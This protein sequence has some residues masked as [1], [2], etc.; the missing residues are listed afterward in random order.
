MKFAAALVLTFITITSAFG[1][2]QQSP[3]TLKIVTEDPNLPS[4]LFY[5]ATK[6][7]PLRLRPGTNQRITWED[8]DAFI[9]QQYIDFLNRMPDQ[10]GYE[11]WLAKLNQCPVSEIDDPKSAVDC[12]RTDVSASFFR[13]PEFQLKGY[14]LLRFYKV[15]LG[16]LPTYAEFKPDMGLVTGQTGEEFLAKRAAF[17]GTF[18]TRT[19]FKNRYDALSNSDYVTKLSQTTGVTLSNANALLS[20]LNAGRKTRAEVLREIVESQSVYDKF[21]NEAFVAMEYFGY[22]KR[23]PEPEGFNAWL[24]YLNK[25][26]DYRTMVWGFAYSPEYR[27]RF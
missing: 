5:G 27:N 1:Q 11:A 10:G 4:E 16:R 22:L 17:P 25:T 9:V 18:V 14:Y 3:P 15:S 13:S 21:Y 7:K 12:G 20:D 24:D 2:T 6:V 19:E 23:D 8:K 26:S